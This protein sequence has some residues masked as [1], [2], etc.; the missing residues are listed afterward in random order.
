[1]P[2][3]RI[4]IAPMTRPSSAE[5]PIPA[6]IAGAVPQAWAVTSHEV[7]YAAAPKNAAC[8]KESMPLKPSSRLNAQANMPKHSSFIM[9]TG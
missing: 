3:R 6:T 1:M 7:A 8:P 9:N 2:W 5:T 4:A